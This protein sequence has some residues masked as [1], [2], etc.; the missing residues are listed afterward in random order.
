MIKKIPFELA[1]LDFI[2]E[3]CKNFEAGLKDGRKPNDWKNIEPTPLNLN[4]HTGKIMRHLHNVSTMDLEVEDARRDL[5]AIACNANIL[6]RMAE[7]L[8]DGE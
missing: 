2:G 1:D 4:T 7:R 8:N 6:Y 5:A 3:M